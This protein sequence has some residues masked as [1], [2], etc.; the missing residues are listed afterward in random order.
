MADL[1]RTRLCRG[2]DPE[3]TAL[4]AKLTKTEERNID[5]MKRFL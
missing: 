2:C 5:D 3:A 4:A 1:N